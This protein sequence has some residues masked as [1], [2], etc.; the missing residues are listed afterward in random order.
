MLL[1][2]LLLL[3][4]PSSYQVQPYSYNIYAFLTKSNINNELCLQTPYLLEQLRVDVRVVA[5]SNSRRMLLSGSAL[6][7][8]E[9]RAALDSPQVQ[10]PLRFR[11]DNCDGSCLLHFCSSSSWCAGTI[12]V[13]QLPVHCHPAESG[14]RRCY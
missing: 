6:Q 7:G 10:L 9:W 5:V 4:H 12:T 1:L 11:I 14:R 13:L 8:T 2:L 3:C